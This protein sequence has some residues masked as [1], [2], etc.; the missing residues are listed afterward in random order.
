M[1]RHASFTSLGHA[2]TVSHAHA[3]YLW[4]LQIKFHLQWNGAQLICDLPWQ[5]CH[6]ARAEG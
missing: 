2:S 1:R 6:R 5:V 3:K 4:E